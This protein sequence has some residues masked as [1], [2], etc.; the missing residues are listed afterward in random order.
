[1][2]ED[3]LTTPASLDVGDETVHAGAT[4]D[5]SEHRWIVNIVVVRRPGQEPVDAGDIDAQLIDT[6]GEVIRPVERPRGV[7]TEAGTSLS[8]S[9]NARFIFHEPEH[10]PARLNVTF[11]GR[12]AEFRI[13]SKVRP[14]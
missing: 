3:L 4:S 2:S 12:K 11:R 1:M 10:S 5:A 6:N 8:S 14:R 9:V 13:E 7:L